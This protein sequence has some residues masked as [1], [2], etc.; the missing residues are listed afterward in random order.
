MEVPLD[1]NGG[2]S[3]IMEAFCSQRYPNQL[4]SVFNFPGK[5]HSAQNCQYFWAMITSPLAHITSVC[6]L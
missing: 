5:F 3:E 4:L 6:G 2:F 1:I